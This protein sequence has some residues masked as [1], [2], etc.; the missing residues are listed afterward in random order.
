MLKS[1][2]FVNMGSKRTPKLA[3]PPQSY[4]I[5]PYRWAAR[6]T[7][8]PRGR[9]R[10]TPRR[11]K[12]DARAALA[13]H[14]AALPAAPCRPAPAP[15]RDDDEATPDR[16][17]KPIPDWARSHNLGDCL[18]R[19]QH[20]D[21]DKVFG[22]KATSCP[23]DDIFKG[24]GAPGG[25]R[26]LCAGRSRAAGRPAG[27][28]PRAAAAGLLALPGVRGP[29]PHRARVPGPAPPPGKRAELPPGAQPPRPRKRELHQR[30]SSG[31]WSRDKV[32]W[33]E[34]ISYKKAMGYV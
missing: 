27:W 28:P 22:A 24:F 8:W 1:S 9:R 6:R 4:E 16:S 33:S 23:L 34:E 3:L 21:P 10:S 7:P 13:R 2:P 14:R 18:R 25:A 32:T 17:G 20:V 26:P 5:S 11:G 15:R 12:G 29:A 31:D 30:T 19:Q